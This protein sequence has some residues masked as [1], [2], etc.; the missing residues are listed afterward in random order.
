MLLLHGLHASRAESAVLT[1]LVIPLYILRAGRVGRFRPFTNERSCYVLG[2]MNVGKMTD[3]S[4][5][6]R[7]L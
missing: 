1:R 3:H 2:N 6:T 4:D 5:G 7:T